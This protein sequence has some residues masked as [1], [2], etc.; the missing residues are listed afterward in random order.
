MAE[1][2]HARNVERFAQLISFV[3]GYGAD[4]APA[5]TAIT[6]VNLQAKLA[7]SQ[8][9]ID[10]VSSTKAPW[11]VAVNERQNVFAELRPL[12]TRVVN[13]FL[14]RDRQRMLLRMSRLSSARSTASGLKTLRKAAPARPTTTARETPLRSKATHSLPSIWIT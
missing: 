10:G 14:L 7:E 8:T 13:S 3:Q 9:G 6:L 2:G 11:T 5:N 1:T 4:Y 12:I